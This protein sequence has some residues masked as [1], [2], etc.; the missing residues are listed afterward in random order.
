MVP[1]A[2]GAVAPCGAGRITSLRYVGAVSEVG[3]EGLEPA[4]EASA[5]SVCQWSGAG[6][7]VASGAARRNDR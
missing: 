4:R 7:N 6:V 1:R 5:A 3:Q 2:P